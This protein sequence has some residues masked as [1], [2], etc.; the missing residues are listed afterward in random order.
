MD[1]LVAEVAQK[2]VPVYQEWI[3]TLSGYINAVIRPQVKGYLLTKNYIEGDGR[4]GRPTAVPDRPARVPGR[5]RPGEGPARAGPGGARQD[6]SSTSRATRRW[7]RKARSASR[8]STTPCRPTRPTW[9]RSTRAKAAVEQAQLNLGWTKVT[10]P[11]DGVVGH[12]HRPDRRPGRADDRADHRLAARP[13]QGRL[14]GQR[15][16]VPALRARRARRHEGERASRKD[17]LELIPAD[18]S[19]YPHRGTVSVVGREVDPRTGT[20]HARGAVPQP[21]QRPAPGRLRQGAGGDRDRCRTRW[22]SRSARV[23]DLQ[24]SDAG[25]GRR[26]GRQGRDARRRRSGRAAAPTGSITRRSRRPATASSPRACRRCAA[27]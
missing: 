18:G 10:S 4:P 27:A 17:A 15:A 3:G 19:L 7:P 1:V 12:R 13:D 5:A 22:S 23:Q 9:R 25:G 16:G 14:P 20:M 21:E 24:G 26:R 11:I 8:S 6:R 2:D